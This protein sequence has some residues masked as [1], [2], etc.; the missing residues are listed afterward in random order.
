MRGSLAR[1][2]EELPD[3][4]ALLPGHGPATTLAAERRRNPF[5]Q[6]AALR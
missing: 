1:I 4:M 2:L 3:S 6:P 5:L